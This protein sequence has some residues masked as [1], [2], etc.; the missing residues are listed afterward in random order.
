MSFLQKVKDYIKARY[1]MRSLHLH[2]ELML[3][4]IQEIDTRLHPDVVR[5]KQE[6]VERKIKMIDHNIAMGHLQQREHNADQRE[7]GFVQR[8]QSIV[9][10]EQQRE[11]EFQLRDRLLEDRF[12]ELADLE[13]ALKVKNQEI[14]NI[15][16]HKRLLDEKIGAL[17][18]SE[19]R[20][21]SLL[22]RFVNPKEIYDSAS[23]DQDQKPQ[24]L[25]IFEFYEKPQNNKL[26]LFAHFDIHGFIDPWLFDYLVQIKKNGFDIVLITTAPDLVAVGVQN[27]AEVCRSVIHRKNDGLDFG[28]WRCA[29][30]WLGDGSQFYEQI[31]LANDSVFGPLEDLAPLFERIDASSADLVGLTESWE[32]QYHLQSYFLCFKQKLI[33]S[34]AWRNFWA[35]PF[36]AKDKQSII[37]H[38]ELSLTRFF[39]MQ[40]FQ[41]EALY[42]FYLLRDRWLATELTPRE[43]IEKYQVSPLVGVNPTIDLWEVLL[44]DFKFPFLKA[45][46]VKVNPRKSD[47]ILFWREYFKGHEGLLK[48]IDNYLKRVRN[49]SIGI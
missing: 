46:L 23:N 43:Y 33:Q 11:S 18:Q 38:F 20:A 31:L 41:A 28:S 40:G 8:E 22:N 27:L 16:D 36:V 42:D 39:M 37:D 12:K 15:D 2:Q 5:H 45:E 26:C 4:K 9:Q 48:K 44:R 47:R 34:E 13:Q 6:L 7:Q 32:I 29:H 14:G 35:Q 25:N 49:G 3:R 17:A 10:R 24:I 30:Q 21:E 1:S 19:K